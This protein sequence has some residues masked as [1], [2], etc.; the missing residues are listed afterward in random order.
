MNYFFKFRI[1]KIDKSIEVF[2]L[3]QESRIIS[4]QK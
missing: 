4:K 1:Y 2:V 3:A